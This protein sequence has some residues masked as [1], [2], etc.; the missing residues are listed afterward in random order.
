MLRVLANGLDSYSD[1]RIPQNHNIKHVKNKVC[2][3]KSVM[4]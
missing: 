2:A 1:V 4:I 3:A